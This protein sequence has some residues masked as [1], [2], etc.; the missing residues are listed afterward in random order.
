MEAYKRKIDDFLDNQLMLMNEEI[1]ESGIH[2]NLVG[3]FNHNGR[4]QTM[5]TRL[6]LDSVTGVISE[7]ELMELSI[8]FIK[9]IDSR[10]N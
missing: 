6:R 2:N 7:L 9:G 1:N 8:Y 10:S 4:E 3:Y 5:I